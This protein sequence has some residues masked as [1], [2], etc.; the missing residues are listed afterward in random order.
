MARLK[1]PTEYINKLRLNPDLKAREIG[2]NLR[3]KYQQWTRSLHL[4]DLLSF[5]QSIQDNKNQI[6]A[7]Q[8]FGKFRAYSLEEF[9]YRLIRAKLSI[10]RSLEVYWGE[11]CL[12]WRGNGREYGMEL[13]I[14][15]GR[16]LNQLVEPVVAIDTKVEL[17]ASRLKT[18]LASFVLVKRWNLGVKCFLVYIIGEI[19][20]ILLK[21]TEPWIDGIYKFGLERDETEKLIESIQEALNRF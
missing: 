3:D 9:V 8:L 17:D 1:K 16:K 19:D 7:A 2:E 5:M 13:D 20:P 14:L 6:G 12:V 4:R 18:T 15:V 11:K 21:L 10:P